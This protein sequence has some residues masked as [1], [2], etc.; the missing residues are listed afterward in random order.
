MDSP[1]IAPYLL[2][3]QDSFNKHMLTQSCV[4]SS[5]NLFSM[6]RARHLGALADDGQASVAYPIMSLA[7]GL[8][9]SPTARVHFLNK[10]HTLAS[11][12]TT[13]ALVP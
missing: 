1:G 4:F 2:A 3:T 9:E 12:P 6:L 13:R 8:G 11:S 5:P 7:W 10:R